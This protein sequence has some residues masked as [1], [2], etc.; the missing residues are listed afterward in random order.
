[1]PKIRS[2]SN[3]KGK[4]RMMRKRPRSRA[5]QLARRMPGGTTITFSNQVFKEFNAAELNFALPINADQWLNGSEYSDLAN[6]YSYYR[7]KRIAFTVSIPTSATNTIGELVTSLQRVGGISASP[8]PA[9]ANYAGVLA[10]KPN[11]ISKPWQQHHWN[12]TPKEPRDYNFKFFGDKSAVG[13]L[14]T[15]TLGFASSGGTM[16][17]R[18]KVTMEF[19]GNQN[20]SAPSFQQAFPITKGLSEVPEM[21]DV[22]Q[23]KAQ[24]T[25]R[26]LKKMPDFPDKEG[27]ISRI[28]DINR[29]FIQQHKAAILA[30]D[31]DHEEFLSDDD[32]DIKI[33]K[34]FAIIGTN[35]EKSNSVKESNY[36]EDWGF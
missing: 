1:M 5:P 9:A 34:D 16:S 24:L 11:K 12:W 2:R 18:S 33:G 28:K 20:A 7:I 21:I 23:A 22:L 27:L 13:I 36:D 8:A 35:G 3:Y 26:D 29:G 6:I 10:L 14:F 4:R 19:C 31:S 15:A 25:I 32:A 30:V 17:I